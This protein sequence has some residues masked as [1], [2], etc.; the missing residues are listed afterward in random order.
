M[1][2]VRYSRNS[3]HPGRSDFNRS[4]QVKHFSGGGGS[5]T[6]EACNESELLGMLFEIGSLS[7]RVCK[8]PVFQ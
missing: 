4:G 6:L 2:L 7:R 1:P 5:A 8:Q 3:D